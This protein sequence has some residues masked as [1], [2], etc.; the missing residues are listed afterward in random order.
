[1]N[2]ES[3][4]AREQ[5]LMNLSG[6][7]DGHADAEGVRQA[8]QAW[9]QDA[10]CRQAWHEWALIGDC[11]RSPEL[12]AS[13]RRDADLLAAVR[14]RL[15]QEPVVLAPQPLASPSVEL[16]ASVAVGNGAA[17]RPLR[18]RLA[19]PIP[20]AVAAG[21]AMVAGALWVSRTASQLEPELA[22]GVQARSAGVEAMALAAS[23]SAV[24][25]RSAELDRYLQ[26]SWQYV[27]LPAVAAAGNGLS[28][29]YG[30]RQV[31]A[32]PEGR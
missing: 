17:V 13:P 18:R 10:V 29:G 2:A 6:L 19:W 27:Q 11:L 1:M 28:P 23:D 24:V 12:V 30:L 25:V 4:D 15:A 22:A 9:R 8:C 26:A 21:C 14:A 7:A 32:I 3:S 20:M 16:D 31:S 5:R